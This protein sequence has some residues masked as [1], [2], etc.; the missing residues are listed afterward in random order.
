MTGQLSGQSLQASLAITH[1]TSSHR[2]SRPMTGSWATATSLR[3]NRRPPRAGLN[4]L[5]SYNLGMARLGLLTSSRP[6]SRTRSPAPA[7]SSSSQVPL[8]NLQGI[9]NVGTTFQGEQQNQLNAD[10]EP[11]ADPF[12]EPAALVGLGA[13]QVN[14]AAR[15][16]GNAVGGRW[17]APRRR[18]NR[19]RGAGYRHRVSASPARPSVG[20][21]GMRR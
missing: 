1:R 17:A 13:T 2:S 16:R 5:N 14:M 7:C 18:V 4:A 21:G 8:S 11:A 19:Q 20:S 9:Y 15:R 6:R 12:V 3:R 10:A